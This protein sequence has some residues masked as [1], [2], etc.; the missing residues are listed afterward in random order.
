MIVLIFDDR[1]MRANAASAGLGEDF[2]RIIDATMGDIDVR[3]ELQIE[4]A[5]KR[6]ALRE[7]HGMERALKVCHLAANTVDS[8]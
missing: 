7:E 1:A 8:S 2:E 5:T 6:K 3:P 4:L